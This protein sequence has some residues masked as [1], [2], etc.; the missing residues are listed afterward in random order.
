MLQAARTRLAQKF[1]I[2]LP[3]RAMGTVPLRFKHTLASKPAPKPSPA[4]EIGKLPKTN[5]G[6][7]SLLS[8]H[9]MQ[10]LAA[11]PPVAPPQPVKPPLVSSSSSS[12]TPSVRAVHR[13]DDDPFGPVN[14]FMEPSGV[15]KH[16]Q[17]SF[18]NKSGRIV[19]PGRSLR[20][21]PQVRGKPADKEKSGL[22]SFSERV[23]ERYAKRGQ[24]SFMLSS[25]ATPYNSL[26]MAEVQKRIARSKHPALKAPASGT[27]KKDVGV[28]ETEPLTEGQ[29]LAKWNARD[30]ERLMF[31]RQQIASIHRLVPRRTPKPAPEVLARHGLGKDA[32][33]VDV[34]EA[35]A[36]KQRKPF[37]RD[38]ALETHRKITVNPPMLA[39]VQNML[40]RRRQMTL[41]RQVRKLKNL[42][43]TGKLS[44][45][46]AQKHLAALVRQHEI[47]ARRVAA[48]EQPEL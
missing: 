16:S 20:P 38:S 26:S 45:D 41:V 39:K 6:I 2:P 5:K 17:K 32:S 8:E 28:P 27:A 25:L 40:A 44:S 31:P 46:D 36:K 7:L 47:G 12:S 9:V 24:S 1:R 11:K 15:V 23:Q 48:E 14:T 13:V 18:L 33:W 10:S 34:D 37:D 4:L 42:H 30:T 35:R 19:P 22:T 29:K 21:I 3:T 43:A